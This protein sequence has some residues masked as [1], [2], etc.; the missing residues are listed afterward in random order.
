MNLQS[1][2]LHHRLSAQARHTPDLLAVVAGDH[3]LTFA[4]LD[5]RSNQ[6]ARLMQQQGVGVE[7]LVAVCLERSVELVVA[8]L[9]VLKTGAAYV[10]IDPGYPP[11]RI[12]WMMA[13]AATA[14]CLTL[15]HLAHKL[16]SSVQ[17][18]IIFL[19]QSDTVLSLLSSEAVTVPVRPDNLAY[20]IYTSG[21]TGRPKGAMISHAGLM[22]Y[23]EWGLTVY[24]VQAGGAPVHSSIGFD[25][26]VTSLFLPLL[27]GQ[28]VRLLPE[29]DAGSLLGQALAEPGGFGL[30]KITPAH[31]LLLNQIVPADKAAA[32]THAF[33]IGGEQLTAEQLAFWRSHAPHTRLFNEYGPTET[34]VGCCVYE[35]L[36][37][38]ELSGALPIGQPIANTQLYVL[39]AQMQPVPDGAV[40]ELFI[41]GLGVARGYLNR[42]SLTAEK[43][44][45]DPFSG[46]PGSRLY[47]TGDLARL[48]P[49]GQFE[50]LGRL[51]HQ[52]KI[53]GYRIELGEI[54]AV[55][56]Q[57]ENVRETAV[58]V[59]ETSGSKQLIAYLTAE[60]APAPLTADLR[61]FLAKRLPEYMVPARF[62]L[63]AAMPL[64]RNGKIDRSAL[65]AP[66]KVRPELPQ[67]YTPPRSPDEAALATIWAEV[68]GVT[69]VGVHDSF[70]GLGGDS[71]RSIQVLTQAKQAGLD[72]SL[73]DLFHLQTIGR[74]SEKIARIEVAE[75]V[76]TAATAINTAPFSPITAADR[77]K[78][79]ADIED[80]FPLSQLQ[81]GMLFHSELAGVGTA[82]YQNVTSWLVQAAFN[83]PKLH[84][85]LQQLAVRHPILRAS[86]DL[87]RYSQPLQIIHRQAEIP[88][89][90]TDWRHL[91]ST[92]QAAALAG[93]IEAE[94]RQPFI[95]GQAPFLRFHLHRC[96]DG[97]FRLG[98]TEHHAILDGWSV[99]VMLT[100]LVQSY[101]ALL[102]QADAPL[103]PAP[104]ALFRDFVALEQTMQQSAAQSAFWAERLADSAII[105]LPRWQAA[106]PEA[107]ASMVTQTF[108]LPAETAENLTQLARQA[109]VPLKSV[110][111]AAHLRLMVLLSGQHDV[112]TGLVANGRPETTDGERVLGLFLN[113]IPFRLALP[114]GTWL[115]LAQATFAAEQELLPFRRFPLPDIQQ[116]HGGQPLFETLFNFIHMHILDDVLNSDSFQLLEETFVGATNYPFSVEFEVNSLSSQIKLSLEYDAAQFGHA[117][118]ESISH[119]CLN[120]L[121]AMG[122]QPNG[123]YDHH[124][125]LPAT[126]KEQLLFAWNGRPHLVPHPQN[127][128]L[129]D[130]FAAQAARTPHAV[131]VAL[132]ASQLTYQALDEQSNQLAH[133]LQWAGVGPEQIVALCLERSPMV[134]VAMLAVLKAGAAYLPLDPD[135]PPAR[136]AYM[137]AD[138]Q[139]TL[140]ITQ[141][142]LQQ[143]LPPND[144]PVVYLDSDWP[145]IVAEESGLLETAVHP[146][147]LAYAIYTSGSTGDPKGV[148]ISHE[149]VVNH[150]TA[151]ITQYALTSS[152]RVL[153]FAALS[154]DVAVEEM[155]PTWLSGG[156]VVLR[157]EE[158]LASLTAFHHFVTTEALTVLNLPASFWQAW[159][160]DLEQREASLPASLRLVITGSEPV[161]ADSWRRWQARFGQSVRWLNAYGPTE[162]TITSTI[163][164]PSPEAAIPGSTMP[165]GRPLANMSA[166]IL[167]RYGQLCPVGTPGELFIGGPG[168][169]RGYLGRPALTAV[170]FPP[171]PI[172]LDEVGR[173]PLPSRLYKTGDLARHLPDGNI[174]FL[175]RVDNQIKIRGF[176]VELGEIEACLGQH[177]AVQTA[178]IIYD[179]PE[180]KQ[181]VAY[182]TV[183]EPSPTVAELRRFLQQQLPPHMIPA[184]F[185]IMAAL[186]LLPN[187]K[188]D[189]QA[190]PK[191][192]DREAAAVSFTPPRTATETALAHIW[193]ELL[194]RE[195]VGIED[196]FFELGGHSLL[197]MQVIA[198]IQH[199]LAV[200]LPLRSLFEAPTIAQLSLEI[201]QREAEQVDDTLL[202]Q[203]LAE[204]DDL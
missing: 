68:L 162:A 32:T 33:V 201:V 164:E 22:N 56:G 167:D 49:D 190:L 202:A 73:A 192:T 113:S 20:I 177:P 130:L 17:S 26:T 57:H 87:K 64:T 38:A 156:T 166:Y 31:L 119:Y 72:F 125:P 52:V 194:S 5:G 25:L 95:W 139:A 82:V 98:L 79:H 55:L 30:V 111:L 185:V 10:P 76:A 159:L 7:S 182:L 138:S 78:L 102:G 157:S 143:Q 77:A 199:E 196:N 129:H 127:L 183:T 65:P 116:L 193:A 34:V 147:N 170:T 184:A 141:H 46:V 90:V 62:V 123:R 4:E 203:M 169:A 66:G 198:R 145:A 150:S 178:V 158:A 110:L 74:L 37:D 163:Y 106:A 3:H 121:A 109:G 171:N 168:L 89:T 181:L 14:V 44:V 27:A 197:A 135:Y 175:G 58:I 179:G 50:F 81:A 186:P 86:F 54:E 16:S 200:E 160:T 103:L 94:K 128:L 153:Q 2:F 63:L 99:A 18:S 70:F 137:L 69:P 165:I 53:R 154:F 189:R 8:L 146:P 60:Q 24:P 39:D 29:G 148:L 122:S 61:D 101:L 140:L 75:A 21:S 152:D 15:S 71:I 13:D 1:V 35:I 12:E 67:P 88:L 85:A 83:L 204:L 100:E 80:A 36:P 151:V 195:Q 172:I 51:D 19:D 132:A 59:H 9:A 42:P 108:I 155:F 41:G 92:E 112:V 118:I 191:P 124:S 133:Y 23:L 48:R 28:P 120:T 43:F 97:T 161:A 149:A 107:A 96:S 114:G 115:E 144:L 47:R 91:S 188:I 174:E 117:Q 84:A 126:E 40:G 136:L 45:P 187:G 176:R 6:L 131:A 142:H 173:Q 93:W 11:D 180:I 105:Q 104:A 134:A